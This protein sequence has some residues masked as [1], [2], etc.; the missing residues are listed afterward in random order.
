MRYSIYQSE[1]QL[2]ELTFHS[3]KPIFLGSADFVHT[4]NDLIAGGITALKHTRTDDS[5]NYY[6]E[7]V[8]QTNELYPLVLVQWLRRKGYDVDEEHPE[9]T[10]SIQELVNAQPIINEEKVRIFLMLPQLSFLEKTYLL[11]SLK[12]KL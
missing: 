3:G 12:E 11:K 7:I 2:G 8:T 9:L 1:S 6:E 10:N 5:V 4:L